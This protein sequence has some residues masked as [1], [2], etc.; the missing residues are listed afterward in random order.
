MILSRYSP[1]WFKALEKCITYDEQSGTFLKYWY[2]SNTGEPKLHPKPKKIVRHCELAGEIITI[3]ELIEAFVLKKR[4]LGVINFYDSRKDFRMSNL[5]IDDS[6][7]EDFPEITD[8]T[9]ANKTID[10]IWKMQ[11]KNERDIKA[12]VGRAISGYIFQQTQYFANRDR[13]GI[14]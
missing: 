8:F 2:F 13:D 7:L 14:D 3:H 9:L 11:K 1:S 12:L 5:K 4:Y 6:L 10:E